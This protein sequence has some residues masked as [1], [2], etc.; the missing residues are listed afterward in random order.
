MNYSSIKTAKFIKR[1]NRFIAHVLLDGRE[2]IV[3]VKNTGRC[4]EILQEGVTVIL[5]EAQNANRKTRYSLI[6][7]YKGDVLINIDSQVPNLV[8]YEAIKEQKIKEIQQVDKLRR[9]TVYGKSRFDLSFEAMGQAGFVEVK[10]ATLEIDGVALFP[11]APTERGCKHVYE[12]IT[13]VENG[14]SGFVFFLIQMKG[15]RYFT[16]NEEMD[17]EFA[18]ALRLAKEKG[19]SILAYDSIVTENGIEIGSPVEVRI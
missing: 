2:E 5:E 16:P 19:V 12:M 7:A 15:I 1:P 14:Y 10:G 17:P 18:A 3:H 4:K 9:E 13:A 11:D 6:A 8:V